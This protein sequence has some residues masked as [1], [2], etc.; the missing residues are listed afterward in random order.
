MNKTLMEQ[1]TICPPSEGRFTEQGPSALGFTE[2]LE[3][4]VSQEVGGKWLAVS[5]S[6][7]ETAMKLSKSRLLQNSIPG[8]DSSPPTTVSCP[9][10]AQVHLRKSKGTDG[11]F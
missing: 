2:G 9:L 10:C 5:G 6:K 8:P 4:N 1:P 11:D 7:S 3:V